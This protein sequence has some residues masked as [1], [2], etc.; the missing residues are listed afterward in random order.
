MPAK[1]MRA[2]DG[3]SSNCSMPMSAAK[4]FSSG[5]WTP[6]PLVAQNR[7]LMP[8][9][10]FDNRYK[11][12]TKLGEGGM[13]EVWVADQIEPIHRRVALKLIRPGLD[14]VRMLARFDQERQALALMDH[15][16]IAKVLDAGITKP[17]EVAGGSPWYPLFR[18]GVDQR[19]FDHGILR[20]GQTLSKTAWNCSSLS[21]MAYSM[22]I[23]RAS[24][25]AI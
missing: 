9:R 15:P 12:R 2:C 3:A 11:L 19:G 1:V 13:G 14:S 17:Q 20:Q 16:N 22:L 8:D 18:H 7:Q 5:A 25:I 24:F 4:A 21:V 6:L 23:K 10:L